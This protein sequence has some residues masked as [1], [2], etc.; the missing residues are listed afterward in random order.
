MC[1]IPSTKR[2]LSKVVTEGVFSVASFIP[3]HYF[4]NPICSP[5]YERKGNTHELEMD[6]SLSHNGHFH[7]SDVFLSAV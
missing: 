6:T 5:E 4:K 7:M 3:A 2:P 1:L